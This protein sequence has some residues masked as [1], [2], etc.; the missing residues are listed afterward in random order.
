MC[1]RR[2]QGGRGPHVRRDDVRHAETSLGNESRQEPAHRSRRQQVLPAF[3]RAET[4]QV[5]REQAGVLGKRG[6]HRCERVQA[7][8]PGAGQQHHRLMRATALGIPDP[9]SVDRLEL[10]LD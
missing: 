2:E 10:R 1:R 9:Q 3:G 4:R 7:L 5:N 6:P 8:R